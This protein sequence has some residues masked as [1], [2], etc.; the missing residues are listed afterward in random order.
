MSDGLAHWQ[1]NPWPPMHVHARAL[2]RPPAPGVQS[3]FWISFFFGLFGLIPA[4]RNSSIAQRYG[5][6]T[7]PYWRAFWHGILCSIAAM[8][9]FFVLLF[10]LLFAM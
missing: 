7:K 5:H 9:A 2:Y 1:I 8:V 3:T 6:S 10:A 4:M